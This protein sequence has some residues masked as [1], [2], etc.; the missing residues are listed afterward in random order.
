MP[1][2]NHRFFCHRAIG[3]FGSAKRD[4]SA[5]FESSNTAMSH[6]SRK[7]RKKLVAGKMRSCCCHF[8]KVLE[9]HGFYL[10]QNIVLTRHRL[11]KVLV[12]RCVSKLVYDG[13]FHESF[14]L[15]PLLLKCT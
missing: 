4:Q 2:R 14:C 15:G 11:G 10:N 3:R 6:D 1:L 5:V 12:A 9:H 8:V 13:C 7:F